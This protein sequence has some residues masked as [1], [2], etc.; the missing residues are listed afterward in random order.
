MK[1]KILAVVALLSLCASFTVNAA[2]WKQEPDGRISYQ[3]DDGSKFA[4]QWAE[5]GGKLYYFDADGCVLINTTTPDGKTVGP[6]G[7]Y[8][9]A[10]SVSNITYTPDSITTSLMVNDYFYE[11]MF[12]TYHFFEVT[13]L[14][15]Y[16]IRLTINDTA[17]NYSGAI[18]GATMS[19]EEDI[20][21]GCTILTKTFFSD[22][23]G[24]SSFDTSFQVTEESTYIPVLQSISVQTSD[25]GDKVAI[26]ATNLG[27]K[28]AEF[29]E[30]TAIF[31]SEGKVVYHGSCYL[32]DVDYELKPGATISKQINAYSKDY[33]S[34][35][36]YLTARK[37]KW[38]K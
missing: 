14:S 2:E 32:T 31:F 24:A 15:P 11:G 22:V 37:S 29:P 5:I 10:Q 8:I 19:S 25:L 4:N 7:V 30:A 26:T 16:T 13:N 9:P 21:S 38:S 12:A 20:P 18:I 17:K 1:K 27:D 35:K 34:V 28:S 6:D 23:S 3:N 33:D 36:V